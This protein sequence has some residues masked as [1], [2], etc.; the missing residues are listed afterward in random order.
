M[1]CTKTQNVSLYSSRFPF[2]SNSLRRESVN[3]RFFSI[4]AVKHGTLFV[5]STILRDRFIIF[6]KLVQ[7][8]FSCAEEGEFR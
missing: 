1:T 2:S 4:N 7:F 8:F 3:V 5:D 6:A